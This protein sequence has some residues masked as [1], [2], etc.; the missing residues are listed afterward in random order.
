MNAEDGLKNRDRMRNVKHVKRI[1]GIIALWRFCILLFSVAVS[2]IEWARCNFFFSL[3]SF[4]LVVFP[5]PFIFLFCLADHSS[6]TLM[7]L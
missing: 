4:S 2:T 1:R 5:S 6:T 3:L 7:I